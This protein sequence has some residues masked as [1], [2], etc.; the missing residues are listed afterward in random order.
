MV[1]ISKPTSRVTRQQ[2]GVL[3]HSK[4]R[5][6]VVTLVP[7]DVLE[8]REQ[9]GRRRFTMPVDSAFRIAVKTTVEAERR[10]KQEARRTRRG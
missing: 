1:E 3:H 8:F 4:L 10:S 7:G 9:G 5:K 2:Y 6:I